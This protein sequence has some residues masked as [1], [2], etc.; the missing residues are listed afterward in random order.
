MRIGIDI[1]SFDKPG[2][3]YGVGPGV[4]VWHL[5]PELFKIGK[6]HKF[7]IF[8]NN[9][10]WDRIPKSSNVVVITDKIPNKFRPNRIFHEQIFIP[11]IFFKY[12]LDFVHY[13]GNNISYLLTEKSI[14][15]VYD[16]MWKYYRDLGERSLTSKYFAITVPYS[17]KKSKA[18][19]T[20]SEF[21]ANEIKEKNIRSNKIY[22][23]LLAPGN[24]PKYINDLKSNY[25]DLATTSY[26]YSVTTS[27]PHKNLKVLLIAFNKIIKE[28]LFIGKLVISGQLKGTYKEDT[29]NFISSNNLTEYVIITGFVSEEDKA[30]LYKHAFCFVFPSLYEGFGL[31]VL[32]AMESNV[33]VIASNAASIPEVG[34]EACLYFNPSSAEDLMDKIVL[35]INNTELQKDLIE[36]GKVQYSKFNWHNVAIETLN[37]FEKI[38]G[39]VKS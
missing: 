16:L 5:L 9:E 14:L 15:T 34:G 18:V 2:E 29:F 27:M 31:P 1:F 38:F 10:N 23:I 20:I 8:A 11:F 22:P 7:Y 32:E 39:S 6:E 13:L 17:I 21:I 24:V 4:Y 25:N 35:L 19:I 30:F 36:K 28:K 12:K 26:I 37:I 33:P 3:N